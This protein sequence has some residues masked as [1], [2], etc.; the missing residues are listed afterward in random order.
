M[1]PNVI[2]AERI[3]RWIIRAVEPDLREG[4]NSRDLAVVKTNLFEKL[5]F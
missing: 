1:T 4:G 3:I 5:F 2:L